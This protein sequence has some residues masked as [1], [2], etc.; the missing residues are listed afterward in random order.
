MTR[1]CYTPRRETQRWRR[2]QRVEH[3]QEV[4]RAAVHPP[5]RRRAAG[6]SPKRNTYTQLKT[7]S[8]KVEAQFALADKLCSVNSATPRRS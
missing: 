7:M 8:E 3:E 6:Q 5:E 2:S 4:R 1:R